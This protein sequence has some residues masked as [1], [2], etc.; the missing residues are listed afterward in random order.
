MFGDT[1][2]ERNVRLLTARGWGRMFATQTPTPFPFEKWGF[3]NGAFKAWQDSGFAPALTIDDWCILWAA[4]E[5]EA[6]VRDASEVGCD[7]YLAVAPD[8]PGSGQQSLE[9]S[10]QWIAELKRDWPWYLAV[11]DGMELRQVES[12]LH[13]FA[14]IFLGGTDKF[15]LTAYHWARL[16]HRHQKKFHYARAG[17]PRKVRHAFRV[18]ADSL[19]STF[20]SWTTQ[21][22]QEL[23]HVWDG[24]ELQQIFD[25]VRA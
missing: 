1:R 24:L 19:D 7:P 14:G 15:K 2:S 10:L 6:R 17:T 21:R 16:A 23:C 11:Q 3:D 5:F 13:L 22:T 20:A 25:E 12:V 9:W 4:E 8:I 18:G